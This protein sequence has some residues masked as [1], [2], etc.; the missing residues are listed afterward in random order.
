M[1]TIGILIGGHVKLE[2]ILY[3]NNFHRGRYAYSTMKIEIVLHL[4]CHCPF[5]K[6]LSKKYYLAD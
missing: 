4:V 2:E 6:Y 5:N 3:F 1:E